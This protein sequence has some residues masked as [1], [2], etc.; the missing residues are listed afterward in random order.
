MGSGITGTQL[1]QLAQQAMASHIGPAGTYLI[2]I[3][4]L[5]F[6]FTSIVANYSYVENALT[7]L[8]WQIWRAS[9]FCAWLLWA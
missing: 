7:F 9:R 5:F 3:A 1:T 8:E 4:I 6:A 2:A